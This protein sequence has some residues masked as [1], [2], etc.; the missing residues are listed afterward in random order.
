MKT[1]KPEKYKILAWLTSKYSPRV[2]L[3]KENGIFIVWATKDLQ[4]NL[5]ILQPYFMHCKTPEKKENL[6][7]YIPKLEGEFFYI[8]IHPIVSFY[9][10]D[11]QI[12]YNSIRIDAPIFAKISKELDKI[13]KETEETIEKSKNAYLKEIKD[14]DPKQIHVCR[15]IEAGS[16]KIQAYS[17]TKF[18]GKNRTYIHI[19]PIDPEGKEKGETK[20]LYGYWIEEEIQKI[21]QNTELEKIPN[22]VVCRLGIT[23]TNPNKK[24]FRTCVIVYS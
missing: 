24:K 20:I 15:D 1:I 13:Q 22:P 12:S 8:V 14:I 19:Q 23:K 9:T 4:R 17:K 16:Y 3:E 6:Y 2:M 5:D 10:G 11:K 7:Y 18:R 21:Q